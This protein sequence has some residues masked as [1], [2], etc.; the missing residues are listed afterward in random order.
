MFKCGGLWGDEK[1]FFVFW[2][3]WCLFRFYLGIHWG[4]LGCCGV[5][6]FSFKFKGPDRP[7]PGGYRP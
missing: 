4:F 3:G 6:E 5:E 1:S 2:G 7:I